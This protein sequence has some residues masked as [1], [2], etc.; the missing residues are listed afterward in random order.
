M[1]LNCLCLTSCSLLPISLVS[2]SVTLKFLLKFVKAL[3]GAGAKHTHFYFIIVTYFMC[4]YTRAV[5]IKALLEL[6][7]YSLDLFLFWDTK[8]HKV[9]ILTL[10]KC[11]FYNLY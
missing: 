8:T 4:P 3:V 1:L 6:S 9:S 10:F 2:V 5:T 11:S 7:F